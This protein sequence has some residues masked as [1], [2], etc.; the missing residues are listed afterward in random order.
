[1][2]EWFKEP[3]L[4]TGVGKLTEGSNPSLSAKKLLHRQLTGGVFALVE[5]LHQEVNLA[6]V[7]FELANDGLTDERLGLLKIAVNCE[8]WWLVGKIRYG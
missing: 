7:R 4:K 8:I 3:V 5:L 6:V 1:M 2:T